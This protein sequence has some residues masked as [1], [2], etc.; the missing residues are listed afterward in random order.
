MSAAWRIVSQS[1]RLPMMI[2]TSAMKPYLYRAPR[3]E[4]RASF[5]LNLTA[6]SCRHV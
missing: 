3:S 5:L 1:E 2:P 4:A 6:L